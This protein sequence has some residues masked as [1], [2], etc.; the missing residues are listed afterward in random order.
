MQKR[1]TK[2]LLD[3]GM[4]DKV[5]ITDECR[6]EMK[7]NTE[8]A[9]IR[10]KRDESIFSPFVTIVEPATNELRTIDTKAKGQ[11]EGK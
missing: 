6:E 7:S 11:T 1:S 4:T 3:E 10:A 8:Q 5:F 2:I 9:N